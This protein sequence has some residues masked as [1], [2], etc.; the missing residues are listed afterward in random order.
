VSDSHGTV[1]FSIAALLTG[2]SQ[3]TVEMARKHRKPLLHLSR[4]GSPSAPEREFLQFIREH[5]IKILNVAGP[6]SEGK[7]K[8]GHSPVSAKLQGLGGVNYVKM[9]KK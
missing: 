3:M 6:R 2:G 8:C 7:G 1:V 9:A 5:R 4:E